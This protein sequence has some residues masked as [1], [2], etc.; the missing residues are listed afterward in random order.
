MQDILDNLQDNPLGSLLGIASLI[1]IVGRFAF[2][3]RDRGR[4]IFRT[5]DGTDHRGLNQ[6]ETLHITNGWSG[7]PSW[8]GY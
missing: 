2:T 4:A 6:P 7:C 8:V 5:G 3:H 1:A